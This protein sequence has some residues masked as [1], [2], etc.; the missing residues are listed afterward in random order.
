VV[1]VLNRLRRRDAP[2]A[3]GWDVVPPVE[4]GDDVALVDEGLRRQAARAELLADFTHRLN[5]SLEDVAASAQV[6]AGQV[7]AVVGDACIVSLLS[8]DGER[9]SPVGLDA[10]RDAV[11]SLRKLYAASQPDLDAGWAQRVLRSG[12]VV[13]VAEVRPDEVADNVNAAHRD[14]VTRFPL[15]SLIIVPLTARGETFGSIA[16]ARVHGGAPYTIEDL[17]FVQEIA[18]RAALALDNA[19]MYAA[20][21]AA[22]RRVRQ[23]QEIT[24]V[25]LARLDLDEMLDALLQRLVVTMDADT[26]RIRLVSDDG[27]ML[28]VGASTGVPDDE[29][30]V[31]VPIGVGFAGTIAATREPAILRDAVHDPSGNA[32]GPTR[33]LRSL[34]GVP[35]L[36]HDR[37]VGVLHVGSRREGRFDDND[38]EVLRLAA[39]RIAVAIER[40]QAEQ[41]ERV[42]RER[43]RLLTDF[44]A[45]CEAQDY[46]T[47]IELIPRLL[48]PDMADWCSVYVVDESGATRVGLAHR[49]PAKLHALYELHWR[50]VVGDGTVDT[51]RLRAGGASVRG[52]V[53]AAD[54]ERF[55][56][57]EHH[58]ELLHEVEVASAMTLPM[59]SRGR[60][61]GS[62]SLVTTPASGR[63]FGD[64]DVSFARE[65]AERAS[66][67]LALS[68]EYA[69][70]VATQEALRY[71]EERFRVAFED[72][73]IGM[74]LVD[75][76]EPQRGR[77]VHVNKAF[78]NLTGYS[79]AELV[80]MAPY[81]LTDPAERAEDVEALNRMIRGESPSHQREQ[82]IRDAH[83]DVVWVHLTMRA[84]YDD[85]GEPQYAIIQLADV[86]ARRAAEDRLV[87]QAL[88]DPLTGLSNRR[89]LM[90]RLQHDLDE[91]SRRQSVVGVFYLDLDRFKRINDDLG[92]ESGDQLLIEVSKRIE[93]VVRP[94]D[95]VARL[96]GDEFVVVCNGLGDET[97]AIGIADRLLEAISMPI[98]LSGRSLVVSPSIGVALTR[99]TNDDPGELLRRADTAMYRAKG[100]GRACFELYDESLRR[101]ANARVQMESD[102]RDALANDGFRLYYQPIISLD[103]GHIV[104]V[105]ALLRMQHP[106][107]GLIAPDEF[108]DIAEESGLIGPIGRWVLEEACR[109]H[110][111]W[112]RLL[113]EPLHLAVNISGRQVA[114]PSLP[115]TVR[116]VLEQSGMRPDLLCLEM[117]E[118]VFMEAV[119]SVLETLEALKASGI[120]LGIDDFGTGY[121]SL[122]YLRNF[123]VDVVKVD[124]SFVAELDDRPQDQAIVSAVVELGR[125]LD[126][127][128][129]AEGVETDR[130]LE[131]LRVLGCDLAQGFHFARPRPPDEVTELLLTDPAW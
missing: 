41:A 13:F 1:G 30:D 42:V 56:R 83:G 55:A 97:D 22:M 80:T 111:T 101:Q 103:R 47:T 18:S 26:A 27:E 107:R 115:D 125:T 81:E 25:G 3:G 95:T 67:A 39:D 48:V 128:T 73:P 6:V 68:R 104:G 118:T 16:A 15:G 94:P 119:H 20:R 14:L 45:H 50:Y 69:G 38:V 106:T 88:H 87:F 23:L 60:T 21:V 114:Q 79:E 58:L 35:L 89:V 4:D 92:H 2:E 123:P 120:Q 62:L 100:R 116:T 64:S 32:S 98:S 76:T 63:H 40:T 52:V 74:A 24:D 43:E 37:L 131:L 108:I 8:E 126:L 33:G 49:D 28:L 65:L 7:R 84:V 11:A 51:E 102:M 34:A 113:P 72:A 46:E 86:T 96:G 90:D 70:R 109:Q 66:H 5:A 44:V 36:E 99:S 82:P 127:T 9:L 110:A 91:L 29:D 117:T 10:P 93:T 78:S 77:I 57:D 53:A 12:E 59:V 54:L 19:R 75:L 61:F 121:S 112:Q 31:P 124:R 85:T 130:Q 129:I 105:E 71:S 122:T 17:R